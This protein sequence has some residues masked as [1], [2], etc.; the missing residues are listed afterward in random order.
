MDNLCSAFVHLLDITREIEVE[1]SFQ[2]YSDLQVAFVIP[3]EKAII[4]A[5]SKTVEL[6]EGNTAPNSHCYYGCLFHKLLALQ[7]ADRHPPPQETSLLSLLVPYIF[8]SL[9]KSAEMIGFA[10]SA[11]SVLNN[12]MQSWQL[13][14]QGTLP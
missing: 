9:A 10:S 12:A 8:I 4:K 6:L 14:R 1:Q 5:L 11:N 7:L 13:M 3:E 2:V